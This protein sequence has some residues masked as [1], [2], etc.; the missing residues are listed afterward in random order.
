MNN[1]QILLPEASATLGKGNFEWSRQLTINAS[2]AIFTTSTPSL[3]HFLLSNKPLNVPSFNYKSSPVRRATVYKIISCCCLDTFFGLLFSLHL[4]T[5]TTNY[6]AQVP[7]KHTIYAFNGFGKARP[8][9]WMD[10]V[11][12]RKGSTKITTTINKT[13]DFLPS[14]VL[15][16]LHLKLKRVWVWSR[17]LRNAG[18]CRQLIIDWLIAQLSRR[19]ESRIF[20]NWFIAYTPRERLPVKL[21]KFF[22]FGSIGWIN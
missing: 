9:E 13:K 5:T 2:Q 16:L 20:P 18:S 12:P 15:V 4:F 21:V 6:A 8:N 17:M 7:H 14:R 10:C 22:L 19:V 3:N 1:H 11:S